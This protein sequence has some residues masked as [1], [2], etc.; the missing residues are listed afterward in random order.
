MHLLRA[1][2]ALIL[3]ACAAAA[4]EAAEL[5][6]K[7]SITLPGVNG[8]IDH[9]AVDLHGQRLFVCALG[10]NTLEVINFG[11]DQRV[12]SI[13]ELGAPQG[14]GYVS[15]PSRLYVAND[16]GGLVNIYDGQSF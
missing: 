9:L 13:A 1:A 15:E 5:R 12:H 10:N 8:R 4:A 7:Q 2:L 11:K 3:C 6:L 16:K 14:V